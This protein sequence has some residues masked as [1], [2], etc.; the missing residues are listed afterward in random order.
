MD[1]LT[2]L[3]ERADPYGALHIVIDDG[4]CDDIH[5]E[6]CRRQP[7]LT[8]LDSLILARLELLTVEQREELLGFGP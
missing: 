5:L 4:N 7:G 6:F 2:K 1:D 8:A 3:I